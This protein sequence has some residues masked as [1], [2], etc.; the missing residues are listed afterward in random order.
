MGLKIIGTVGVQ[1]RICRTD[2]MPVLNKD[3]GVYDQASKVIFTGPKIKL[4]P[5]Y[6]PNSTRKIYYTAEVEFDEPNSTDPKYFNLRTGKPVTYTDAIMALTK[7]ARHMLAEGQIAVA[8]TPDTV[9]SV[10]EA[11]GLGFP[12]SRVNDSLGLLSPANKEVVVARPEEIVL[13][14][15]KIPNDSAVRGMDDLMSLEDPE[16]PENLE[17]LL[18]KGIESGLV[19]KKGTYYDFK[20]V[21]VGPGKARAIEALKTSPNLVAMLKSGKAPNLKAQDLAKV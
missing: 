14:A 20:T 13:D 2:K 19:K 10:R 17:E 5:V 11:I 4:Y 6:A 18:D 7:C 16:S 15:V 9:E 1:F 3:T 12:I 21:T 8:V